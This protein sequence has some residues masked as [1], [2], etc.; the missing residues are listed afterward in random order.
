M[1]QGLTTININADTQENLICVYVVDTLH[2]IGY[3]EHKL[4]MFELTAEGYFSET[5]LCENIVCEEWDDLIEKEYA[6]DMY[7]YMQDAEYHK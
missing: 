2:F 1:K 3:S 4:K 6:L 7:D 5:I